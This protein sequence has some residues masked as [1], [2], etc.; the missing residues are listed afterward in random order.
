MPVLQGR[1]LAGGP[2][3]PETGRSPRPWPRGAGAFPPPDC[4]HPA[5]DQ[6][7]EAG[8][9]TY[10]LERLTRRRPCSSSQTGSARLAK[11][12]RTGYNGA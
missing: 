1:L 8:R 7:P 6:W 5:H 3:D 12:L 4:R 10:L 9:D 2:P 11:S